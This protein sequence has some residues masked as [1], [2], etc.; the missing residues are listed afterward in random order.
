MNSGPTSLVSSYHFSLLVEVCRLGQ[1]SFLSAG[2]ALGG[3]G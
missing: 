3:R 2:G 1:L